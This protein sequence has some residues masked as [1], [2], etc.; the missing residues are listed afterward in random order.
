MA[1]TAIL[2]DFGGVFTTS[3]F[4]AFNRYER[5]RGIP[6]DFIR[7]INATN[8]DDNAWA[9]LESS[10]IDLDEFDRLFER[11]SAA[12]GWPIPGRDVVAMLSGDLRPRMVRA[13]ER[14]RTRFRTA[15][16]TNNVRSLG[17]PEDGPVSPTTIRAADVMALFDLVVESSIEG[18]RK[19]DPRIYQLA[20]Q[21]LRVA[22]EE[23]LFIDDL[24]INCKPAAALGMRTIKVLD[25]DQALA[26]L[27]AA[28]GLSLR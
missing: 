20:C 12:A 5:E 26:D 1:L 24:G 9:R 14:I 6:R 21:R 18:I 11:E 19:P 4:E 2:F 28:T 13:L 15:C 3:P 10:R 7:G 23:A 8:P 17:H 22:P 27:E 16:I 25:E